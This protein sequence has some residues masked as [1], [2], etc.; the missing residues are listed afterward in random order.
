MSVMEPTPS[1]YARIASSRYGHQQAI[2]DEA[3]LVAGAHR[4]FA[5]L[6]AELDRRVVDLG[7]GGD[8]LHHFH[9]LH[10][11]NGIEEVQADEALGAL[12]RRHQLGDGDRRSVGGE[13][14]VLLDDGVELRVGLALLSTFSMMASM[15]MSQSARSCILS[16]PFR[17]DWASVFC[18]AVRPPLAG[19]R[20]TIRDSDFSMPAKPLSRN[21]CSCSSTITSKTRG[22][23]NLRD[24]RAHQTTT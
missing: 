22:G 21:F 20:S 8:G 1:S 5:E 16:V 6:G 23:R 4:N 24:A 18:S 19:P 13:D 2:D 10:H 9:Q 15:T 17:C 11:R 7:R 12:G 14:R 3:G